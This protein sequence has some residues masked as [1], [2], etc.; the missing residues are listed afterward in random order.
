MSN[1]T[2]AWDRY[3][4]EDNDLLDETEKA[5]DQFSTKAA[6]GLMEQLKE[7]LQTDALRQFEKEFEEI[8]APYKGSH[9]YKNLCIRLIVWQQNLW[10]YMLSKPKE[11]PASE[12]MEEEG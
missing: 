8:V 1:S 11:G 7:N 6:N 4:P 5:I 10:R 2:Y 9:N 12:D 3:C